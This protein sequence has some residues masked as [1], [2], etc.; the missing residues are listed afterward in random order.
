[1]CLKDFDYQFGDFVNME[2]IFAVS[3][4]ENCGANNNF[5]TI[6]GVF[7]GHV[8]IWGDQYDKIELTRGVRQKCCGCSQSI[9][10]FY[11]ICEKGSSRAD[12]LFEEALTYH[13]HPMSVKR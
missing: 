13:Y 12:Q 8:D 2:R 6:R 4:C 5:V 11:F 7:Q 10:H 3:M 1:M 9:T